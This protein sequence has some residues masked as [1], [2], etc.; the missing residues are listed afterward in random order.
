VTG[1]VE[2]HDR[3]RGVVVPDVVMDL[4]VV[5]LELPGLQVER[6]DRGC[7]EVL[8]GAAAAEEVAARVAGGDVEEAELRVDGGRLPDRTP[9]AQVD[10]RT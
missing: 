3:A 2:E 7:V 6:H 8:A 9:A 10:L 4:L 5:P 1:G